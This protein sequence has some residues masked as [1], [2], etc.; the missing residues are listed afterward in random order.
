A[1]NTN[2][3]NSFA[4]TVVMGT[5]ALRDQK[6]GNAIRTIDTWYNDDADL[7]PIAIEPNGASL[8]DGKFY[9]PVNGA[10]KLLALVDELAKQCDG[11]AQPDVMYLVAMMIRGGV[12]GESDKEKPAKEAKPK[13]AEVET[14]EA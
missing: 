12:F 7:R 5:A 9:R 6:I 4:D 10:Y 14:E 2:D 13:K 11:T 8:S 3:P 1:N